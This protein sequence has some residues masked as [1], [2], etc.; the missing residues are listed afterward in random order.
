M[1]RRLEAYEA[2]RVTIDGCDYRE[3]LNAV[4]ISGGV[5][6]NVDPGPVRDRRST[7]GSRPDRTA[8]QAEAHVREVFDGFDVDGDRLGARRPAGA[9]AAPGRASSWPRSARAPMGK[10]G[11]TDVARFAALGVPALNFGP[12]DPN[13]AHT[14]DE[15]VEIAKIVEGAATLRRWLA[16]PAAG[17]LPWVHGTTRTAHAA[18]ERHRGAVTLRGEAIP[19]TTADQHLLDSRAR[20][21]WKQKDAWRALRILSEFVEGF[22][23]PGRPAAGGERLRLGPGQAGQR[24]VRAGRAAGRRAGPGRLR[25]DH[26]RRAGRDGGGEQGRHARPAGS[27]SG[28]ASSCPSSRA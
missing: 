7:S 12:G 5:A 24:R 20:A 26:R 23:T 9:A 11:W 10:L 14:R 17:W 4:G 1:L 13:L 18:P 8:E 16:R 25:G 3:G 22:D 19:A 27:P 2:R 15:H 21:D 28:S 6:G